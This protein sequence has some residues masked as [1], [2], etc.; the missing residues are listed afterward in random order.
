[1]FEGDSI[2]VNDDG[3]FFFLWSGVYDVDGDVTAQAVD[4]LG[5][6]SAMDSCLIIT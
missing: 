4:E 1:M 3:T 6:T 2:Q 5:Q